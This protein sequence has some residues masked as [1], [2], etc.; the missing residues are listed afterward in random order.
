M[1]YQLGVDL[2]TTFTA[3][4]VYRDGQVMTASL[5]SRGD[6]IPSVLLIRDDET[7][8]VGEA[9]ERRAFSEPERVAREFKRRLGDT[10]PI[11]IGGSP[12]SAEAL[13]ARLLSWVVDEVSQR[14]GGPPESTVVCH[15]ANWGQYKIELLDQ[16][17]Q[18]AGLAG[19]RRITEPEA[20][21]I[22]YSRQERVETGSVIAVYDLGGGTF[23]AAV[24][25]KTPGGFEVLGTPKGIERLGGI[26]F[27][28][29]IFGHVSAA[30]GGLHGLDEDDS[31]VVTAVARLRADCVAAKETLSSDTDATIPVMLPGNTT[32]VRLTRQ[33]FEAMIRP[34]LR[35]SIG[36]LRLAVESA[37][38]D[39]ADVSAVLLVGGS[40]RIPLVAQLVS[41]ELGR[42]VNVDTH[43]KMTIALGA[44]VLGVE[45][46]E[47]QLAAPPPAPGPPLAATAAATAA[48]AAV[49][50]P[51]AAAMSDTTGAGLSSPPPP[52]EPPTPTGPGPAPGAPPPGEGRSKSTLLWKVGLPV[53]A[54]VAILAATFG[55]VVGGGEA[56]ATEVL[57]EPITSVG[58]DPFTQT[59]TPDATTADTADALVQTV[60]DNINTAIG[61]ASAIDFS[62]IE[63]PSA[64]D[65]EIVN[66][67]GSAPGLYGGTNVID[68]CDRDQLVDFLMSEPDKGEAWADVQGITF[69]QIPAFVA[70]LTD[71]ILPVD[72]RVTNHGFR[73]GSAY[74]INSV[75]QAGTAVLVDSFG[76]P[77]V[78][79][80]CGNPLLQARFLVEEPTITG[81]TWEG[82]NLD[83]AVVITAGA[84]PVEAF[85]IDDIA[86]PDL[87]IREPGSDAGTAEVIETTATTSTTTTSTTTTSTTSTTTT[88]TTT[89]PD[90]VD[91][92]RTGTVAASSVFG[93]NQYPAGLAVDGNT[94]TSWFSAGGGSAT[95]TWDLGDA[96]AFIDTVRIISNAGNATT[97]FR[98][99]FG[100]EGVTVTVFDGDEQTYFET[101]GL[102]GTPDPDVTSRPGVVG[103]RIVLDFTG[104]ESADC[105]GF[106]ELIVS[107]SPA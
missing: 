10:T 55:F 102:A 7:M 13:T 73:N 43:P 71:V 14:E 23:D 88:T 12:F 3:A 91:I 95:Y 16:A 45:A 98:T 27:D 101:F 65:G 69:E 51:A 17:I 37:G 83:E 107:G 66:I 76:V 50:D 35:D 58:L 8:L 40:S 70:G 29:G 80:Y 52:G 64:A 92:S 32:E 85:V 11:L 63:I 28:A 82:F 36:A 106:G 86:G 74:A 4:A 30:L 84:E 39:P 78:R 9:A 56:G 31:M 93:G 81:T 57:L 62:A 25:R 68:V 41:A 104:G 87:L 19:A 89:R 100:F 24:L 20:A 22:H 60:L 47:S 97:A 67:S 15:P 5:G 53:L 59:I 77:R 54:V 38:I 2:G 90:P 46:A 21:A 105:G 34:S 99:N 26:D 75:L 18:L 103:S 94:A 96:S 1:S 79:C 72:T 48:A 42:P 33:E 6:A 44:A 49:A 61:D